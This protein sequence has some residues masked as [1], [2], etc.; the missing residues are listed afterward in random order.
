MSGKYIF[1]AATGDLDIAHGQENKKT[2]LDKHETK[3][4]VPLDQPIVTEYKP[5]KKQ[6]FTSL[7]SAAIKK[8]FFPDTVEGVN[9]FIK[10]AKMDAKDSKSKRELDQLAVTM[11]KSLLED[12]K[13]E[14]AGFDRLNPKTYPSDPAKRGKLLEIDNLEKDL[15]PERFN[16]KILK[17]GKYED[18]KPKKR[19]YWDHF[20]KTGRI[21]EPTKEEIAR[22][23]GPSTWDLIYDS[24]TP[25]EKGQWNYEK[26]KQGMNGKTGEP[27]AKAD[28][29]PKPTPPIFDWRIAP[30][31]DYPEDDDVPEEPKARMMSWE[32]F[33]EATKI[34]KDPDVDKGLGYLLGTKRG[35]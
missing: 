25:I 18:K 19:N 26:R 6:Q 21:L 20:R 10:Y 32:E 5:D 11:K 12:Y 27:L 1:N 24:M 7:K 15:E 3:L 31:T 9:H 16:D 17:R 8:P 30:W 22:T 29:K 23:K 33:L 13:K 4:G 2:W 34:D 28:T 14:T 35:S